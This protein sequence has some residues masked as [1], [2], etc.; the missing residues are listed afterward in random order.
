MITNQFVK[1]LS[2]ANVTYFFIAQRIDNVN[3]FYIEKH[4]GGK[5]IADKQVTREEMYKAY[6]AL[7]ELRGFT[8]SGW[9]EYYTFSLA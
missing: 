1:I 8:D 6:R 7:Q 5:V 3:Y 4:Y 9:G 2:N